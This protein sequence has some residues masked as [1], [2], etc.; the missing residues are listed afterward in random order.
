M[1]GKYTP[2][3]NYLRDLPESQREITLRFEQIEGILNNKLPSSAYGYREWWAHEKE[4]NHVNTRAWSNAGWMVERLDFNEKW[5]K[6]V[7]AATEERA[8]GDWNKYPRKGSGS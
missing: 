4:G 8:Q 6:F 1:A 2:L 5:V 7:R 3:E